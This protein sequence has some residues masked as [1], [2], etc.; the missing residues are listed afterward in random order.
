L[1]HE[2]VPVWRKSR[3]AWNIGQVL[4]ISREDVGHEKFLIAFGASDNDKEWL[5]VESKPF[6][7]YVH[8]YLQEVS[9]RKADT[10]QMPETNNGPL[11]THQRTP[12]PENRESANKVTPHVFQWPPTPVKTQARSST[13]VSKK[14]TP[15]DSTFRDQLVAPSYW[16]P[17][18]NRNAHPN[19][20]P[21]KDD[22]ATTRLWTIKVSLHPDT[23]TKLNPLK[24]FCTSS[25]QHRKT[26]SCFE[27]LHL[28]SNL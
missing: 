27:L 14:S 17:L 15:H 22:S 12:S 6:E 5:E 2:F 20:T 1:K 18:F 16:S 25:L 8:F 3:K 26:K 24:Q 11:P 23:S 4:N 21:N 9:H 7:A 19:G 10:G 28:V 13:S